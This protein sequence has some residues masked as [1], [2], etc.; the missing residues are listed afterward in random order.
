MVEKNEL[1]L[2]HNLY[3][4]EQIRKSVEAFSQFA[5]IEVIQGEEK[6]R[7]RFTNEKYE[8][9]ILLGEFENYLIDLINKRN[10]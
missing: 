6:S 2:Y 10:V 8:L 4:I 7:V 3:P 5:R 9:C 1:E